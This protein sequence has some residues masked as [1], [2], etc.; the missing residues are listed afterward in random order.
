MTFNYKPHPK[1]LKFMN[2]PQSRIYW[3]GGHPTATF[4]VKIMTG[5]ISNLVKD[6]G[7]AFVKSDSKDYFL[8]RTEFSGH[9]DDLVTDVQAGKPVTIEFEEGKS[10]KGPRAINAKRSDWPNE[11]T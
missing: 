9:W 6:K 10:P 11:S 8:H 7:Y 3:V 5:Y 1:Q 4:E 2:E